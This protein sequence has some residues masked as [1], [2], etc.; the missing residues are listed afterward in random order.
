MKLLIGI[1]SATGCNGL[2]RGSRSIGVPFAREVAGGA[3][4]TMQRLTVELRWCV[5]LMNVGADVVAEWNVNQVA[6]SSRRHGR[7]CTRERKG[8][9]WGSGASPGDDGQNTL[10]LLIS[11]LSKK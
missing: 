11:L 10:H 8:L 3:V 6:F 1:A 9:S 4:M 2:N 5:D 7:L